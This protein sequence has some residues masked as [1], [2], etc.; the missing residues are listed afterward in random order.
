MA[1]ITRSGLGVLACALL[2]FF[3]QTALAADPPPASKPAA[4]AADATDATDTT[5]TTRADLADD[6]ATL[7]ILNRDVV[8]LRARVGGL[9]PKLRVQR[10]EERLREMPVA[11]IDDPLRLV[12]ARL[13]DTKG[14]TFLLGGR[15]LFSVVEGDVDIEA[16]QGFDALVKETQARLENVR[17]AWHE[18]HD[19]QRLLFGLLRT[20]VASLVFGILAWF[21]YRVGRRA[22]A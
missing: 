7:R 19:E 14:V 6:P 4:S 11:A 8:T 15:P 16:R 12:Q 18:V 2:A 13:G 20:V 22:V 17:A 9:T 1:G 3:A 10:A 21:T 5:R